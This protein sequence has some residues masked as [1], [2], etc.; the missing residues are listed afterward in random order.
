MDCSYCNVINLLKKN[1]LINVHYTGCQT[2]QESCQRLSAS[3]PTL[4][5]HIHWLEIFWCQFSP[6]NSQ[7]NH[8]QPAEKMILLHILLTKYCRGHAKGYWHWTWHLATTLS[9]RNHSSVKFM[10]SIVNAITITL[11]EHW[12]FYTSSLY[13]LP[14]IAGVMLKVTGTGTDTTLLYSVTDSILVSNLWI[15]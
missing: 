14:L 5:Y 6:Y 2:L 10:D 3:E 15:L 11:L 12:P 8:N 1:L 13:W 4:Y 7:C 9:D